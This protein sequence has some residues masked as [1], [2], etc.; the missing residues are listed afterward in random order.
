[1]HFF[2]LG[3]GCVIYII[4]GNTE[5]GLF[6]FGLGLDRIGCL[7]SMYILP[8]KECKKGILCTLKRRI[9]ESLRTIYYFLSY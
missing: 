2:A 9:K 7:A 8:R 1:M 5:L 4:W 6:V 3:L